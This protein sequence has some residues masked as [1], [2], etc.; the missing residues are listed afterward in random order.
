MKV[1]SQYISEYTFRPLRFLY[2]VFLVGN[3]VWWYGW[4]AGV[5]GWLVGLDITFKK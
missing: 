5:L 3:L 4:E 1:N 2:T